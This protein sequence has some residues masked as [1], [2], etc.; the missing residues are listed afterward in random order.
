VALPESISRSTTGH[1]LV[2]VDAPLGVVLSVGV[3]GGGDV[4]AEMMDELTE[5]PERDFS[6]ENPAQ[7]ACGAGRP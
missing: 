4:Q 5:S 3:S 1:E 7:S 2:D 6:A